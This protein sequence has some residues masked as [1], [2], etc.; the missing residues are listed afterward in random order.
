MDSTLSAS[1]AKDRS[2]TMPDPI[3][4]QVDNPEEE[5]FDDLDFEIPCLDTGKSVQPE[6]WD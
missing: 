1:Y 2:P 6:E 5:D 3:Y 4:S